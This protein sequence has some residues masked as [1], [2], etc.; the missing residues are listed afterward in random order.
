MGVLA[1]VASGQVVRGRLLDSDG[2]TGIG[3]AM[4]SLLDQGD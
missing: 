2:A 4:I 1:P 3:G